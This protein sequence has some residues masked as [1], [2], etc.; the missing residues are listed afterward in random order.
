LRVVMKREQIE[1]LTRV[2]ARDRINKT[3]PTSPRMKAAG[4][5]RMCERGGENLPLSRQDNGA[6]MAFIQRLTFFI[7]ER[8]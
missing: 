2:A 4:S 3:Q 5:L 1:R 6:G 8:S 7:R